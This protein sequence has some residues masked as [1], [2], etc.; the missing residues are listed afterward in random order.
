M[1]IKYKHSHNSPQSNCVVSNMIIGFLKIWTHRV[2]SW[3]G[4]V[5]G[6]GLMLISNCLLSV[7]SVDLWN[8]VSGEV[9]AKGPFDF[10]CERPLTHCRHLI[11][12]YLHELNLII[13]SKG[14]IY[15]YNALIPI[16]II[17]S[18]YYSE[19]NLKVNINF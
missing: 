3:C 17:W 14:A 5:T 16:F 2:L 12:I 13:C 8:C 15:K 6:Q 7:L 4:L 18:E 11:N 9:W 10:L 1:P 19:K